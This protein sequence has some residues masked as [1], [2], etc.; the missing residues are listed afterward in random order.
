M[1]FI[2]SFLLSWI[3]VECEGSPPEVALASAMILGSAYQDIALYT[4]QDGY[5]PD[6]EPISFCQHTGNWSSSYFKCTGKRI[7][8]YLF[9]FIFIYSFI[10]L[11]FEFIQGSLFR[12]YKLI[13]ERALC[14]RQVDW[15]VDLFYM[16]AR[17][18]YVC[19]QVRN[20]AN[21][22]FK[23]S[24]WDLTNNNINDNNRN[25]KWHFWRA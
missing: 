13:C 21:D 20:Q 3:A 4:C 9:Y 1:I 5:I 12:T 11:F 25:N 6:N 19:L 24:L 23:P 10:H 14:V 17:I 16:T 2:K 7:F 8:I 22:G 15:F 18:E